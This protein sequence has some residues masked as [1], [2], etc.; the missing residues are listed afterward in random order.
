VLNSV[1]APV[2]LTERGLAA[3]R[4]ERKVRPPANSLQVASAFIREIDVGDGHAGHILFAGSWARILP[5]PNLESSL[6]ESGATSSFFRLSPST[7]GLRKPKTQQKEPP[8]K[9]DHPETSAGL[10]MRPV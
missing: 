7:L 3:A 6:R 5:D 4:A 9:Y 1:K 8:V 10:L 2:L